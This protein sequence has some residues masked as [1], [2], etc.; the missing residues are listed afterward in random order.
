MR[1]MTDR[2]HKTCKA[3]GMEINVKRTKVM[4]MNGTAKSKWMQRC[5]TLNKLPLEQ[6]TRFKCIGSWIAEDTRSGRI[7]EQE[8]EWL[9]RPF[10]KIKN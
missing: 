4:I 3:L 10:G 7:L 9:K 6:V 1:K 2:I 5:I 8:L